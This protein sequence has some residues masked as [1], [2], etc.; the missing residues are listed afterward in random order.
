M[1]IYILYIT[2]LHIYYCYN[3]DRGLICENHTLCA[4]QYN[5]KCQKYFQGVNTILFDI[6]NLYC[7]TFLLVLILP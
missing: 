2:I 5:E 1:Y 6:M 4:K 3:C 7:H